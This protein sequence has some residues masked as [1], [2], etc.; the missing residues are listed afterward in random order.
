MRCIRARK[1]KLPR[2]EK[3]CDQDLLKPF[4]RWLRLLGRHIKSLRKKRKTREK[5]LRGEGADPHQAETIIGRDGRRNREDG[6]AEEMNAQHFEDTMKIKGVRTG[7]RKGTGNG[8]ER[9]GREK[10]KGEAVRYN[11]SCD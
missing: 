2:T 9:R 3:G 7:V 6:T 4:P 1:R 10:T 8:Q 5:L 11:N